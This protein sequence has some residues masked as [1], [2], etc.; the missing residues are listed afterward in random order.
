MPRWIASYILSLGDDTSWIEGQ[1]MIKREIITFAV[2]FSWL[3]VCYRLCLA[4]ADNV[5]TWDRVALIASMMARYDIDFA[6]IIRR[7]LLKRAFSGTATL[8]F[9]CIIQRLYN[10]AG[11]P[12]IPEVNERVHMMAITQ[13]GK[14]KDLTY[15]YLSKRPMLR[16]QCLRPLLRVHKSPQSLL[17]HREVMW[18]LL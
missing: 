14:I 10:E 7:G 15:P 8:P 5:Q 3:L 16:L 4:A 18:G 2:K 17:I 12:E 9:L 6:A 1:G 11:V 13:T